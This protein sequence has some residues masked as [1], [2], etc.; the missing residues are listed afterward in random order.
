[1]TWDI[2]DHWEN[3]MT[4]KKLM[5][6]GGLASLMASTA[7]ASVI[8]RPFFRVL[9]VVVVWAADETNANSGAAPVA[10]DFVLLNG[11]SG[12]AGNDLIASDAY[13]VITGTMDPIPGDAPAQ[14]SATVTIDPIT[15]ETTGG[16]FTDNG[17]SGVLDAADTL[18]AFG[19]DATT[20]VSDSLVGTHTSSFF[21][22]SNAAFDIYASRTALTATGDFSSI[23]PE[24]IA[25][26]LSV[27]ATSGT[28]GIGWGSRSQDPST[29]GTGVATLTSLDDLTTTPTKVFDGGQRTAASNGSISQQS[30]RF[31]ATYE[32]DSDLTTAG[33]QG[34]DLSQGVGTV[35]ADVTYTVYVP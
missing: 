18:T 16:V 28:E 14:D 1:M 17:T 30:V 6:A 35:T 11:T 9:G 25:Y 23:T 27:D 8:D 3:K 22:A 26:S 13:T 12:A 20:D 33:V 31:D 7:Y 24:N 34:Y 19:M 29:G 10:S 5:L 32:L 2:F 21:V 4:F 15:G